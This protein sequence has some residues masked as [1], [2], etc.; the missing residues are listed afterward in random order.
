[1]ATV[2]AVPPTTFRFGQVLNLSIFVLDLKRLAPCPVGHLQDI[3]DPILMSNL[4]DVQWLLAAV[5]GTTQLYFG[6]VALPNKVVQHFYHYPHTRGFFL[7]QDLY[8]HSPGV[9]GITENC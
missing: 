5:P 9:I 2:G 6:T 8:A 3:V 1:M 4:D 7:D